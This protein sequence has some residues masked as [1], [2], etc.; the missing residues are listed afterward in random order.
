MAGNVK[1]ASNSLNN[2]NVV[3][4]EMDWTGDALN[5]SV[6]DT[7]FPTARYACDG[8]VIANVA[9]SIGNIAPTS[10]YTV[11]VFSTQGIDV[12]EGAGVGLSP[13]SYAFGVSSNIAPVYGGITLSISGNSVPGAKGKIVVY[14][15]QVSTSQ[16]VQPST[17][18]ESA[19]TS[20]SASD[21]TSAYMWT[22]SP[23][24]SV[25]LTAGVPATITLT[26]MPAGIN[27]S[28]VNKHYVSVVTGSARKA[29]LI[30]A[31]G[32][33]S[34]T[35]TP[36]LSYA[37]GTWAL[38]S[39]SGGIQE[40]IYATS[41]KSLTVPQGSISYD[42]LR[43]W[44]PR[45]LQLNGQGK[46]AT[47]IVIRE[48][49]ADVFL[50][51]EW[52]LTITNMGFRSLSL[53][54]TAG[55]CIG[56]VGTTPQYNGDAD[57]NV[58][59]CDFYQVWDAVKCDWPG[60]FVRAQNTYFRNI[61][62][63]GCYTKASVAGAIQIVGNYFDGRT[64][65]GLIWL[66]GVLG[67]GVIAANWMQA[68]LAHVAVNA[69]TAV[70]NE[71]IITGNLFDQDTA[72]TACVIATGTPTY[73]SN[74]IKITAN[75]LRT[76]NYAVLIQDC[77]NI[78]ISDNHVYTLGSDPALVIAGSVSCTNIEILGNRVRMQGA[79]YA[80]PP[81][82]AIQLSNPSMTNVFVQGNNA[83]SEGGN[84]TAMIGIA[85]A[86]VASLISG[87]QAGTGVPKLINDVAATGAGTAMVSGNQA[88]SQPTLTAIV[89]AATITLPLADEQQVIP[90]TASG[91]PITEMNGVSARA[92]TRRTFIVGGAVD[93][94][95]SAATDNKIGK[96]YGPTAAGDV[97]TFVKFGDN[98][99]YP[100]A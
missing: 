37:A 7:A 60:G 61:G 3:A 56:I 70:V 82:Y 52:G 53:G 79:A 100:V 67:G 34:I 54:Q 40:A 17:A 63:Y 6:P 33:S 15:R 84:C 5:G 48:A 22:R 51:D 85:G 92:G 95:T 78:T 44:N 97:V 66:E 76:Q 43:V 69:P 72:S 45:K 86:L 94:A 39:A 30:T 98:L 23:G 2:G 99:W 58:W 10:G 73:G 24:A 28:S 20:L 90:I 80:T 74:C 1:I 71:L 19:S 8:F 21:V 46:D 89:A 96:A 55:C 11:R 93:W 42:A 81:D 49:T 36:S 62:R 64:S 13:I 9:V 87:N 47:L 75:Y 4:I 68:S 59:D 31:V 41:Y 14:F 83:T 91:T 27:S 29:Y 32:A 88:Y 77:S 26:P 57:V 18:T 12:L 38:Q 25:A 35:F 65:I 16:L 50:S